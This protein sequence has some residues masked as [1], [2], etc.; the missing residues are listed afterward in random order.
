MAHW[1]MGASLGGRRQ[2]G[3]SSRVRTVSTSSSIISPLTNYAWLVMYCSHVKAKFCSLHQR[4]SNSKKKYLICFIFHLISSY[5][6]IITIMRNAFVECC[7]IN[8][9]QYDRFR[10]LSHVTSSIVCSGLLYW[11]E[12]EVLGRTLE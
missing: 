4:R 8:H 9:T 1:Y 12:F 3:H 5:L 2:T 6:E 10:D 7:K 11:L